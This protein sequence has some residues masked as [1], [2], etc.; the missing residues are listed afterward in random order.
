MGELQK[1]LDS[2]KDISETNDWYLKVIIPPLINTYQKILSHWEDNRIY[3]LKEKLAKKVSPVPVIG[4]MDYGIRIDY[5]MDLAKGKVIVVVGTQG[6]PEEN[7]AS[8][9]IGED[10]YITPFSVK[11]DIEITPQDLKENNIVLVGSPKSN[12]LFSL[13]KDKLPIKIEEGVVQIANRV[14]K[15]ANLG[16]IMIAPNPF[17]DS[18]FLWLFCAFDPANLRHIYDIPPTQVADYL[19]FQADFSQKPEYNILEEGYFLKFTP[20]QWEPL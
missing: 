10:F 12:K 1:A 4:P 14:Y 6:S 3:Q 2:W 18:K 8:S 13:V 5:K 16:F 15:G 11:K 20:S 7:S 17:N 19:L 9:Q